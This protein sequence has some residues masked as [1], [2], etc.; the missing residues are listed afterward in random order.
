MHFKTLSS[1]ETSTRQKSCQHWNIF[2]RGTS[3]TETWSQKTYSLPGM[4]I[5]KSRISALRKSWQI[6]RGPCVV[7]LS[8]WRRRSYRVKDTIKPLIGGPWVSTT[9]NIIFGHDNGIILCKPRKSYFLPAELPFWNKYFVVINDIA[10][11]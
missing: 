9:T 2:T 4:A 1:Q 8:T 3:C 7:L 10:V 5:W 11:M 6:E